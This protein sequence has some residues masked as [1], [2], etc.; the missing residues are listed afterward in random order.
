[1]IYIVSSFHRSGSSMMM[2]CLIAGG[3]NAVWDNCQEDLNKTAHRKGYYPN[4]NGFFALEDYK[5]K[6]PFFIKEHDKKLIKCPYN[7]LLDLPKHSYKLIFMKRDPYEIRKSMAEFSPYCSWGTNE[8]ITHFYDLIVG[9]LTNKITSRGDIDMITI[10][11]KDVV[12]NPMLEFTRISQ[13]GW[14]INPSLCVSMVDDTLYRN[15]RE[16]NN[17]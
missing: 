8:A 16:V 11:Y 5:Y 2:K 14:N 17:D 13:N 6:T 3:M 15:R 9:E 7:R 12:N 10:N 4:P 1:M